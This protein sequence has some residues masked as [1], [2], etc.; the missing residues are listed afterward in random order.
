LSG[1][2]PGGHARAQ[3]AARLLDLSA[4]GALLAQPVPLEV[5][6]IHDFALELPDEPIWVQAEVRHCG[7]AAG[8][9][10]HVGIEFLGIDPRDEERLRAYLDSAAKPE[11]GPGGN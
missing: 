4:G 8:G 9:G 2:L 11:A 5:G 10:W 1:E 7:P 3:V 6:A